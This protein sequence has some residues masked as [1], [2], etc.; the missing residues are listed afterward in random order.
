MK[1]D[2]YDIK[3]LELSP[4]IMF[5]LEICESLVLHFLIPSICL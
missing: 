5:I 4:I 2:A 1:C 3:V